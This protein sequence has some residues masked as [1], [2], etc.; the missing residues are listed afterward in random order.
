MAE[1]CLLESV[2]I[3][4][5]WH[6]VVHQT[7]VLPDKILVT[8]PTTIRQRAFTVSSGHGW[9][10]GWLAA[11]WLAAGW[12]AGWLADC[13]PAGWLANKIRATANQQ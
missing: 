9:L 4:M 12:L 1:N 6:P 7:S 13:W 10:T 3:S 11:G 2:P 8:C 5:V